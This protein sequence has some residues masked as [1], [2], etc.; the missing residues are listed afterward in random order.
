M[1]CI[2]INFKLRDID[3][4]KGNNME[5]KDET[6]DV[7]VGVIVGRFQVPRLHSEHIDLIKTVQARHPRVVIIIG[8]AETKVTKNNPLDYPLRHA[9]IQEQFPEVDI[10]YINDHPSDH[11]WSKN[12]D[13]IISKA[14]SGENGAVLYGSRDS[15]IK[16]YHGKFKNKELIPKNSISG[17]ELRKIEGN[18]KRAT[19]DFR[20]GVIWAT[21]NRYDTLY[22]TVDI[23]I[24]NEDNSKVLLGRKYS[25]GDRYRFVGG[26]C[27]KKS[28]NHEEDAMREVHEE[29]GIEVS[30]LKYVCSMN[31]DDWRYRGEKDGIRTTMFVGKYIFGPVTPGDDIDE[32]KWFD[33][34]EV[35]KNL[36][37]I[38]PGHRHL[39]E[40][41]V[42]WLDN[43]KI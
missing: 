29:L 36:E 24:V 4:Q 26:F 32:A 21:Q 33:V 27:S 31:I 7:D 28:K 22:G 42:K 15:F 3:K 17:T 25:D 38:V 14:V 37:V 23:A 19:E 43:N 35:K 34:S 40:E 5:V 2:T 41:L 39:F 6:T 13:G 9:M 11:V 20:A 10:Y 16:H 18:K 8:L 30:G 12:L 1:V